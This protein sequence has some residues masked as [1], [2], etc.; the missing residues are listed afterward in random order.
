MKQPGLP[1]IRPQRRRDRVAQQIEVGDELACIARARDDRGDRRMGERQFRSRQNCSMSPIVPGR[2][3]LSVVRSYQRK[4]VI[5]LEERVFSSDFKDFRGRGISMMPG[6]VREVL[7][8]IRTVAEMIAAFRDEE[9][10][11]GLSR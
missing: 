2:C 10:C 3:D 5:S 1:Q 4:T 6:A 7:L 11:P 9:E 8:G